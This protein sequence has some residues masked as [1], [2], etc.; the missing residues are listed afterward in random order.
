MIQA[1]QQHEWVS[2][3]TYMMFA[4]E[5]RCRNWGF[6]ANEFGAELFHVCSYCVCLLKAIWH[7][8][9]GF[10][11]RYAVMLSCCFLVHNKSDKNSKMCQ[12][13]WTAY[14]TA[15]EHFFDSCV[16]F[17]AAKTIKKY[18]LPVISLSVDTIFHRSC[19]QNLEDM[20]RTLHWR[21]SRIKIRMRRSMCF[22]FI[23]DRT[24][25]IANFRSRI[26]LEKLNMS[27]H[28]CVVIVRFKSTTLDGMISY[29]CRWIIIME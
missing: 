14:T 13:N 15:D 29:L 6:F 4:S 27:H 16:N 18:S 25:L 12:A 17:W 23:I 19:A 11:A 1:K 20:H 28:L 24:R 8:F 9:C 10:I 2:Y 5:K 7:V 3:F 22:L 26:H 21:W